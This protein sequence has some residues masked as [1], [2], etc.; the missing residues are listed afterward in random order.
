MTAYQENRS[1]AQQMRT[2]TNKLIEEQF[3]LPGKAPSLCYS[4]CAE[5]LDRHPVHPVQGRI[6]IT[7]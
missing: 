6:N 4:V 7:M 1:I 3:Q 2:Q 5:A